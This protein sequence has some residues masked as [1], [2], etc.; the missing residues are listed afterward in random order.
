MNCTDV[1]TGCKSFPAKEG[2]DGAGN[3]GFLRR[4]DHGAGSQIW[5]GLGATPGAVT[6]RIP[7]YRD[8]FSVFIYLAHGQGTHLGGLAIV[9]QAGALGHPMSVLETGWVL[10]CKLQG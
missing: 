1:G 7:G 10:T 4:R 6:L 5:M 9:A 2:V 8:K 3:D